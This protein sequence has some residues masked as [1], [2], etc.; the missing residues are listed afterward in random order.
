MSSSEQAALT[1]AVAHLDRS[2]DPAVEKAHSDYRHVFATAGQSSR[3]LGARRAS[4]G[5][6]EPNS[7]FTPTASPTAPAAGDARVYLKPATPRAPLP[8]PTSRLVLIVLGIAAAVFAMWAVVGLLRGSAPSWVYVLAF[9]LLAAFSGESSGG[10]RRRGRSRTPARNPRSLGQRIMAFALVLGLAASLFLGLNAF[11]QN[12]Q[13][14]SLTTAKGASPATVPAAKPD[15]TA[16][17]DALRDAAPNI[18]GALVNPNEPAV[19]P[20]GQNVAYEW[21]YLEKAGKE[22]VNVKKISITLDGGGNI[23]G[24][25]MP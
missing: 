11:L 5:P 15:V 7:A 18:Y 10:K 9:L 1:R 22:S 2:G 24:T 4:A 25:K 16:A 6:Q 13:S 23:I 21:E 3:A 17:Q 12:V 19:A 14:P 20:D 8:V